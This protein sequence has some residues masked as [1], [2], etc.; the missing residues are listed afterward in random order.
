MVK[1]PA[2]ARK[3]RALRLVLVD[4][5]KREYLDALA[6]AGYRVT[7]VSSIKEALAVRPRPD[8]LILELV[9]PDADLS[10]MSSAMKLGRHT[11]AITLIA[12]ASADRKKAIVKAGAAFC[13]YPC[14]PEELLKIVK[15][16]VVLPQP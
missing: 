15:R 13:R 3:P 7:S 4:S 11:R 1:L 5:G 16:M 10:L 8:G 12:L 6:C 2:R 14:P 9:V